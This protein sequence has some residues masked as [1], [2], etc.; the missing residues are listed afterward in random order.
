MISNSASVSK[1]VDSSVNISVL[2]SFVLEHCA[3]HA[4]LLLLSTIRL[5]SNAILNED[6]WDG[7][8]PASKTR[9]FETLIMLLLIYYPCIATHLTAHAGLCF[10]IIQTVW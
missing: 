1:S 7:V 3:L 8:F 2:I 6:V 9:A 10:S 4:S 5:M